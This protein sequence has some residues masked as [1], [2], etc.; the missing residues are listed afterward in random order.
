[1]ALQGQT[2]K[3]Q[4]PKHFP[5][6]RLIILIIGLLLIAAGVA[7]WFLSNAHI[8][9]ANWSNIL[10]II[11]GGGGLALTLIA[12]LFPF[13]ADQPE[14]EADSSA[15]SNTQHL[16]LQQAG[17]VQQ[18]QDVHTLQQF[19]GLQSSPVLQQPP[20]SPAANI[21]ENAATSGSADM[22]KQSLR[23]NTAPVPAE[24][25]IDEAKQMIKPRT[26][27]AVSDPDSIFLFNEQLPDVKEFYGRGRERETLINRTRKGASTS[28]VGPRRIGKTWLIS[29]LRKVALNDPKFGPTYRIGYLDAT[30]PSCTPLAG[31]IAK[32]LEELEVDVLL[33]PQSAL[34]LDR[35]EKAVEQLKS[36][37][38]TPVLCIDEFEGLCRQQ[39][40]KL[41]FLEN[42][43]AITQIGLCLVV[44]SQHSLIDVVVNS[45]GEAARPSPFFNVFEQLTLKPFSKEEAERF[46]EEKSIQA[47]FTDQE[48]E[49]LIEYGK[50]E[51]SDSQWPPLRLDAIPNYV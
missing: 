37:N 50:K 26:A 42:L 27:E 24:A 51:N 49:R 19:F 10:S 41:E 13:P 4:G 1:M 38:L 31:F 40:F 12:W 48:R 21:A 20:S 9:D 23:D 45:V 5:R 2:D 34:K 22:L 39:E 6:V 11:F 16:T 18:I 46:A 35:L 25:R 30:M 3:S 17:H 14:G 43:R 33:S 29:Y 7:A 8:I 15:P 44:A 36:K 28:I 47:R 32:A